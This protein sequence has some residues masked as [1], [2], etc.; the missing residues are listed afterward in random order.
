LWTQG[1]VMVA[2]RI[3]L[4]KTYDLAD[5]LLPRWT[6]RDRLSDREL[7]RR[8][9]Q[10]SLRALGVATAGNITRH[11]TLNRYPGLPDVLGVL[12]REGSIQR[13]AVGDVPGEW[14]VHADDIPLLE[15]IQGGEWQGRT[16]LLSPFDNAIYERERAELIFGFRFRTEIYVPKAARRYGYYLLPILHGDRLIG[17][18]DSAMD[19]RNGVL[20]VK[21]IHL[22][23]GV[24]PTMVAGRAVGKALASLS[25]FLGGS[26]V[27]VTGPIPLPWRRAVG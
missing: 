15:R 1:T 22:E 4:E 12:E 6:P 25:G 8:A 11:Y 7:T 13:V 23:A 14:F 9:A 5:K 16:T 2:G 26:R 18:V 24:R 21:A 27:D 19:R 17:R 10:R 20:V 3:G